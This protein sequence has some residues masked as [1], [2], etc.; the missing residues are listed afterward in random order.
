M[1]WCFVDAVVVVNVISVML[2]VVALYIFSL[3]VEVA[4][5]LWLSWGC[6]NIFT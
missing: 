1:F 3:H 2:V 4:V 6:D 5:A